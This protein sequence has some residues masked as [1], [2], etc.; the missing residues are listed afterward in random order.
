MLQLVFSFFHV[1]TS[2]FTCNTLCN[3]SC[4]RVLNSRSRGI[5]I[6]DRRRR[7]Y[8]AS[9]CFS[10]ASGIFTNI[11]RP[12]RKASIITIAWWTFSNCCS[13]TCSTIYNSIRIVVLL[14]SFHIKVPNLHA[15]Y[16]LQNLSLP[17]FLQPTHTA[18]LSDAE[19]CIP[20][21]VESASQTGVVDVISHPSAYPE[22]NPQ[23]LQAPV[24][25]HLYAEKLEGQFPIS[26][27]S[28]VVIPSKGE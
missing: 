13:I 2:L 19:S 20:V 26:E 22:I 18:S 12:S 14:N 25:R 8:N 5:C 16:A 7:C 27:P 4:G 23:M 9:F 17:D 1:L 21:V 24:E 6:T 10:S 28:P 15:I 11:T 3:F